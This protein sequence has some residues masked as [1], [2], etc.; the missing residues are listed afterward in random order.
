MSGLET[1]GKELVVERSQHRGG[2]VPEAGEV[3]GAVGGGGDGEELVL[4]EKHVEG[5]GKM[6]REHWASVGPSQLKT[7]G[8]FGLLTSKAVWS[9]DPIGT[10]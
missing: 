7:A 2:G 5:E 1:G 9:H 3:V 4:P 10:K 6:E 8:R